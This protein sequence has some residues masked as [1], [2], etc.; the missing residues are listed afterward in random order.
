MRK[1]Q[2]LLIL[3]VF[4]L[5]FS[6]CNLNPPPDTIFK[7]LYYDNGSTSGFPPID[8]NEYTAGMEAIVLDKGSLLKT[9]H[10][11]QNWNTNSHGTGT[12]YA[13]GD[14]IKIV[15]QNIYLYAVWVKLPK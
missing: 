10:A 12:S 9:E 3:F 5:L 14:K 4:G 1:M 11:F 6:G 7:V 15:K 2:F 13:S 8:N